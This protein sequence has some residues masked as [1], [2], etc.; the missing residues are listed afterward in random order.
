MN[1]E[2]LL[3]KS[4]CNFCQTV[5]IWGACFVKFTLYCYKW[6]LC[7]ATYVGQTQRILKSTIKEHISDTQFFVYLH[8]ST[9]RNDISN[10]KWKILITEHLKS[11]WLAK[12]YIKSYNNLMNECEGSKLLTFLI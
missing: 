9:Y 1:T 2:H 6:N 12:I 8:M 4:K 11:I 5:H 3:C 7:S 10:F